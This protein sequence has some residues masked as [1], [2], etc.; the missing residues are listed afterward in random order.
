MSYSKI[1]RAYAVAISGGCCE[2]CGEPLPAHGGQMAHRIGNT[3]MNRK[4]WG[5]RII[6]HPLNVGMTCSLEC[7]QKLDISYNPGEC[8]KLV[9]KIEKWGFNYDAKNN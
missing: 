4:K 8:E 3:I 6:D 2:V 9:K 7:N 5:D 1:Q